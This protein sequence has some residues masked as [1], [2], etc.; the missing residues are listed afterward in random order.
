MI[1]K[2]LTTIIICIACL[3]GRLNAMENVYFIRLN[4]D[5]ER[6]ELGSFS[7][8]LSKDVETW[9]DI[10]ATIQEALPI[11]ETFFKSHVPASE[12]SSI[13][14]FIHAMWGSNN[15]FV[16]S[17]VLDFHASYIQ[18]EDSPV[19]SV[20]Y[21]LWDTRPPTYGGNKRNALSSAELLNKLFSLIGEVNNQNQYRYNLMCHSMGNKVFFELMENIKVEEKL[22]HK[23]L[24]AAADVDENL[25]KNEFVM[26]NLREIADT[27][28][29]L[30]NYYDGLLFLSKV[31]NFYSPL[32]FR[33]DQ[34]STNSYPN[35]Q[36]IDCS[37]LTDNNKFPSSVTG[38]LYYSTSIATK[39][40]IKEVLGS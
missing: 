11:F 40:K 32:G 37:F 38:H 7:P 15:M 39:R 34:S 35:I 17:Q 18:S 1:R 33:P 22:F 26:N 5:D 4:I 27:C 36:F 19:E 8:V 24:F 31:R 29:V 2:S 13:L 20:F 30:F 16:R 6:I 25:L 3:P 9:V 12:Q 28:Y 14:F 21:I 23:V 10:N